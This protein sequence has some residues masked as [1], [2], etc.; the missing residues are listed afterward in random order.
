[1]PRLKATTTDASIGA[2][3]RFHRERL[4]LSQRALGEAIRVSF[5]QMQKY[6]EGRSPIAVSRLAQVS[7]VLKIPLASFLVG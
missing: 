6:E 4:G 3:L 2:K 1:M 7:V 5:Q